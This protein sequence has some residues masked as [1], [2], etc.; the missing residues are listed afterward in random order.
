MEAISIIRGVLL[1]EEVAPYNQVRRC[2]GGDPI[3]R[4]LV[5]IWLIFIYIMKPF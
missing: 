3:F 4:T 2:F 1:I 5:L